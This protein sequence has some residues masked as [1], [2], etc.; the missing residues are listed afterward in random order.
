VPL[1][2]KR[3]QRHQPRHRRDPCR[4]ARDE[5]CRVTRDILIT[6]RVQRDA[7]IEVERLEVPR[8]LAIGR[9]ENE[10]TDHAQRVVTVGHGALLDELQRLIERRGRRSQR[11]PDPDEAG[12]A[13]SRASASH[14]T[15][16]AHAAN[17]ILGASAKEGRCRGSRTTELRS[18]GPVDADRRPS[19][20]ADILVPVPTESRAPL[21]TCSHDRYEW[22][23]GRSD[24]V[25]GDPLGW[26]VLRVQCYAGA[27]CH[28]RLRIPGMPSA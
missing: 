15:I 25:E 24:E 14:A 20:T 9:R 21:W 17:T 2:R 8:W 3:V 26:T 11:R 23:P 16:V 10:V 22:V 7:E 28:G 12:L 4:G 6:Q 18:G 5:E 13:K 19:G 1:A 27:Q